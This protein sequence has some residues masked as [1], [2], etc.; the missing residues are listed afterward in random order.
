MMATPSARSCVM[1]RSSWLTSVS[2]SAEVG[3]SMMISRLS[4]DSARA[5]STSCCSA[6]DS[7]ETGVSGSIVSPHSGDDPGGLAPHPSPVDD[8]EGPQRRAA[9]ENVLGHRQRRDQAQFLVDGDDAGALGC[10]GALRPILGAI[11]T[12]C[13]RWSAAAPRTGS[14]AASTCPRRSRRA[15]RG[16]LRAAH[17]AKRRSG[18]S[19]RQNAW[20]HRPL[21]AAAAQVVPRRQLQ[22]SVP[23]G[24]LN[25]TGAPAIAMLAH[26]ATGAP[27][28]G[29]SFTRLRR[30][31]RPCRDCP[32]R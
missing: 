6:T 3:S 18:R 9:D 4:S 14:S 31:A 27:V 21:R 10:V 30:C 19:R 11:E 22:P 2:V 15:A 26:R 29:R 17:R 12:R 20:R 28:G 16:F 24:W 5:I 7:A 25:A 32:C 13:A 1:I 8:A 23:S